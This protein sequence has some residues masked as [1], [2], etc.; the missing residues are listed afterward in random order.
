VDIPDP[1]RGERLGYGGTF[2]PGG[3]RLV[4]G[5]WFERD[6]GVTRALYLFDLA[7]RRL[8]PLMQWSAREGTR[9]P[10]PLGRFGPEWL[11]N[12][13]LLVT[14]F[15]RSTGLESSTLLRLGGTVRSR[16]G[17]SPR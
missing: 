5:T 6:S 3:N 2:S 9:H 1:P 10:F 15:D 7:A 12:S 13:T 14:Q 4:L 16:S 11:D 8:K 17:A